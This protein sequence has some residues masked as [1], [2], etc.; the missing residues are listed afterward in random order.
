VPPPIPAHIPTAAETDC[1]PVE[2]I[3][4]DGTCVVLDKNTN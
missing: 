3:N 1:H 4:A 2:K